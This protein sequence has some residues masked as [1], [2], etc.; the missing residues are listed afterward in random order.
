MQGT[1]KRLLRRCDELSLRPA[2]RMMIRWKITRDYLSCESRG[3]VWER[4]H[5][6][7]M[8][9]AEEDGRGRL[10]ALGLEEKEGKVQAMR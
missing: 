2:V 9:Q 1:R 10:A 6:I 5:L 7:S 3:R 4:R 8:A